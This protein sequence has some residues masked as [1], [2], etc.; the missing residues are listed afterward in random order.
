MGEIK[1]KKAALLEELEKQN[2][3]KRERNNKLST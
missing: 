3:E 2:T 1:V